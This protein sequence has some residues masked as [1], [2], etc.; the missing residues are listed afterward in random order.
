MSRYVNVCFSSRIDRKCLLQRRGFHP[1]ELRVISR[2]RNCGS[3]EDSL[4]WDYNALMSLCPY[5][6][7]TPSDPLD[8]SGLLFFRQSARTEIFLIFSKS[9]VQIMYK[10]MYRCWNLRMNTKKR[11]RV[12]VI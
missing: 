3:S 8:F 6:G 10:I 9:L 11:R 4:N 12:G 1:L 2:G 7:I 5:L